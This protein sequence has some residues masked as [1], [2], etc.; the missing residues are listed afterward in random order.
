MA[1]I[2]NQNTSNEGASLHATL[3][4]SHL[5]QLDLRIPLQNDSLTESVCLGIKA[6][7]ENFSRAPE[8]RAVLFSI[9]ITNS[10]LDV[11]EP[12]VSSDLTIRHVSDQTPCAQASVRAVENCEKGK[13]YFLV[14]RISE[15]E[16]LQ[17]P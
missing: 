14:S 5:A 4:D 16:I 2:L 17:Q 13:Y 6:V 8:I 15:A 10:D 11:C 1:G 12:W 7:F 9:G 3:K